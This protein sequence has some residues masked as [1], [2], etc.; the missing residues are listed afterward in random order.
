MP[1]PLLLFLSIKLSRPEIF[2]LFLGAATVWS[3]YHAIRQHYGFL[4]I[5]SQPSRSSAP[6]VSD[7]KRLFSYD[8][9]AL[10][11][12]LIGGFALY[13]FLQPENRTIL[14]L[15]RVFPLYLERILVGA[16]VF[17]GLATLVYVAQSMVRRRGARPAWFLFAMLAVTAFNLFFVGLREPLYKA[18]KDPEQIFLAT[19]VVGGILHGVP[20]IALVLYANRRRYGDAEN[21]ALLDGMQKSLALRPLLGYGFFVALSLLYVALNLLR[22]VS[23]VGSVFALGT[24][25]AQLFLAIYWGVFFHHYYL[26]SQIWRMSGNR[27]LR[28]ELGMG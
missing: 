25:P 13:L 9:W 6:S 16:S 26:D 5:A 12:S 28:R 22:G 8:R 7:D 2:Q 3:F 21:P 11:I 24:V 14:G 15:P 10:Y 27:E 17:L 18:A 4:A 20:Y 19:A 23:P 1:G